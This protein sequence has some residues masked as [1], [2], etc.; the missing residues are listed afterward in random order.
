MWTVD[1][2]FQV[3]LNF[4]CMQIF[5]TR[6][7]FYPILAD[8]WPEVGIIFRCKVVR[9][10]DSMRYCETLLYRFPT[11]NGPLK[12]MFWFYHFVWKSL[13]TTAKKNIWKAHT[14][15][16]S[17]KNNWQGQK[18]MLKTVIFK[19]SCFQTFFRRKII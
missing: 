7:E 16:P 11:Y 17:D 1:D 8:F 4:G 14:F 10:G 3:I 12:E 18:C 5:F 6:I 2:R 9:R 13:K 15:P 19:V